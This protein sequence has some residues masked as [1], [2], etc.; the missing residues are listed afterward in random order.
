M[1]FTHKKKLK[2]FRLHQIDVDRLQE[3][4][5]KLGLYQ[6]N[7]VERALQQYFMKMDAESEENTV[8]LP[9]RSTL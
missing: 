9:D 3:A 5:I 8:L 4:S 6:T 7:I 2:C 1:E